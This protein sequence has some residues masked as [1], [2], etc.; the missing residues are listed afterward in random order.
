MELFKNLLA[1]CVLLFASNASAA[2]IL[3]A[4]PSTS[5]VAPGDIV[6]I[7]IVIDGLTA[8]AADS[9]GAFDIEVGFDATA[10]SVDS[11]SVGNLLGDSDFFEALDDSFVDLSGIANLAVVSLLFDDELDALQPA[12]FVLASIAFSVDILDV[13]S[14]TDIVFGTI[15]LSDAFGDLLIVANSNIATL[16]N[17]DSVAVNAPTSLAL[18]TFALVVLFG[19]RRLLKDV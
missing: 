17:P 10:L 6:Q 1:G 9:L 15:V 8:D 4:I 7:D 18:I 3:S 12:S 16:T 13:G 14:S 5:N 11:F 19:R 2:I